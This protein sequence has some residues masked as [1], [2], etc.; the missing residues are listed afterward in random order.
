LY[1]TD[2]YAPVKKLFEDL[3]FTVKAEIGAADVVARRGEEPPVIIELKLSF[4]LALLHQAIARQAVSD[5]VYVAVPKW[6]GRAGWKTFKGNIGLCRRLGLG[7]ISVDL[8]GH[9][10]R[11]HCDPAP[12]QPRKSKVKLDRLK[13]EFDR[14]EG[15]PNTGGST[16]RKIMTAY[17]QAAIRCANVLRTH[18]PSR[19]ADVARLADVPTATRLMADN[20]YGWFVRIGRGIYDLT[21]EGVAMLDCS[22]DG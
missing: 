11:I 17:R 20:H 13:A 9:S 8:T 16:R 7:L 19:G 6:K 22:D 21:P 18:G 14:R 1:E 10:A 15:D 5:A 4:T 3:G 12:Y 2:L